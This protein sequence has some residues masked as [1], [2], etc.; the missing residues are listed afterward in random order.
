[1]LGQDYQKQTNENYAHNAK[2][3]HKF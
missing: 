3:T 1:V 2:K